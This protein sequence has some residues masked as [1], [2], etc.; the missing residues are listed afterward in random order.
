[1]SQRTDGGPTQAP[2][3]MAGGAYGEGQALMG[4]Q[5]AAPMAAAPTTQISNR[6]VMAANMAPITPINAP[7]QR[8]EEPL[9]AGMPFGAGPGPEALYMNKPTDTLSNTLASIAQYDETGQVTELLN[10]LTSKGL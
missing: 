5:Q 6:A 3:Y 4:L 7:T 2:R 1:M 10:Y 8:P 9:T